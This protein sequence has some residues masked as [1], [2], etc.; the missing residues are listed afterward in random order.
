ML[1][2]ENH[3]NLGGGGCSKLRLHYFTLAWVTEQDSISK[4]KTKQKNQKESYATS[5][6]L[7]FLISKVRAL[8]GG[9]VNS[10]ISS[11]RQRGNI[12]DLSR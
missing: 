6:S 5:L 8:T 2:Q 11:S 10:E 12:T 4:N 1:R 9:S 3:L 7:S